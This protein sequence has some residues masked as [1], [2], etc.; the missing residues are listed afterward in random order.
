[1]KTRIGLI[2]SIVLGVAII[3]LSGDLAWA[4]PNNTNGCEPS[5]NQP[6]KCLPSVPGP[7]SSTPVGP[8]SSTPVSVPEPA[9]MILLGAGVVGIGIWRRM[10]RKI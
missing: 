4:V 3:G 1:M 10:S 5:G 8:A 9:S 7:A 6:K 2:G